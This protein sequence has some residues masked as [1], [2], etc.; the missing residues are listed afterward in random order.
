MNEALFEAAAQTT[1]IR[2]TEIMYNPAGGRDYEFIELKNVGSRPFAL[3]HCYFEGVSFVFPVNTPPLA[4][5]ETIVLVSN[6]VAFSERY[7]DIPVRGVYDKQLSNTGETISL[8]D[9]QNKVIASV[10]YDDKNGWPISPDGLGD[11]L[12]FMNRAGDPN[13]PNNWRAST[14]IN[15]SPGVDEIN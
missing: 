10:T 5:D 15:G 13:D 2:L 11:S 3:A 12:V 6:A 1:G 8:K 14:N 4:P 9:W 7:S